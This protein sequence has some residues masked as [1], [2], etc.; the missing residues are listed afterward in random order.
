MPV[1]VFDRDLRYLAYSEA[2]LTAYRLPPADLTGRHHYEVFPEIGE[3]WRRIHQECLGGRTISR[4]LEAF[5]RADGSVDHLRWTV[6]PWTGRDGRIGGL[7][8][9]TEVL[10]DL[11]RMAR[12]LEERE[13]FIRILF[14]RSPLGMNLSHL[15]G[16]WIQSNPAFLEII[17]YDRE[18][19]DGGLTYW[20]LTPTRYEEDERRQIRSL[21]RTGRY[22]PYEKEFIRKDGS[23]VPVRL[24]GFLVE[25]EGQRYI[26]SLIEDITERKRLEEDVERERLKSIQASKLATLGEMAAGIAHEVNNPLAVIDGFAGVLSELFRKGDEVRFQEAV[27]AIVDATARATRI[28]AGLRKFAREG[29]GDELA[30]VP[31]VQLLHEALRLCRTRMRNLGVEVRLDVA[32]DAQVRCH[33]IELTQV[34]INLLNNALHAA[35]QGSERWIALEA[36]DE[37]DAL[38]IR[39]RDSGPGIPA[40]CDER[41]FE[42]FFTT[43]APGEGTGLGLSISRGIVERLGGSLT[44]DRGAAGTCFRLHLPRAGSP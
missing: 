32:T 4:E 25:R 24:N 5:E 9:Y 3:E 6:T 43:K 41:I 38:E 44:L 36:S 23:L 27:D 30:V 29:D 19:A 18:E 14:D 17:G 13:D 16:L 28:V 7:V 20:D 15:N 12:R 10:T 26:W 33:E 40:E 2:W 37:G 42:P 34:L 39:V 35:R 1:A 22:G 21:E 8:M 31:A 11:V